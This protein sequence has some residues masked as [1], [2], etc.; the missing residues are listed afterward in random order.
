[1]EPVQ[2]LG[3]AL[4]EGLRWLLRRPAPPVN[5]EVT[6]IPAALPLPDRGSR[7]LSDKTDP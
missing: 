7:A 4:R 3:G 2:M 1:M 5:M 6:V